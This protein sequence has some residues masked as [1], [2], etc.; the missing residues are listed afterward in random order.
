MEL[1]FASRRLRAMCE[2]L[3]VARRELGAPV[4]AQLKARIA[5]LRAADNV[6]DLVL[7]VVPVASDATVG[8]TVDLSQGYRMVITSNHGTTPSDESGD[9]DWQR[10]RRVEV[11]AIDRQLS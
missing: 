4:A 5:D 6:G 9:V 1:A 10:V 3:E 8:V 2:D 11:V 7:G